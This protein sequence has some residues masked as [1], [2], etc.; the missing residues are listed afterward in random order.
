[1][2]TRV[3]LW[4][5]LSLLLLSCDNRFV[6]KTVK[7]GDDVFMWYYFSQIGNNS[8]ERITLA[9]KGEDEVLV[10]ESVGAVTNFEVHSDTVLFTIYAPCAKGLIFVHSSPLLGYTIVMDRTSS[11]DDFLATPDGVKTDLY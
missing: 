1:M 7:S 8:T 11:Y 9:R 3:F 10:C 5:L 2:K 4:V 6:R